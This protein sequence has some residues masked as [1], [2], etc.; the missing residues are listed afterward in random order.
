MTQHTEWKP[1]APLA[2]AMIGA[3]TSLS[4]QWPKAMALALDSSEAGRAYMS[5]FAYAMKGAD[6]RAI[7]MAARE[8]VA[9]ASMP[10]KP[11]DLGRLAREIT[12]T[13][14]P[15]TFRESSSSTF[16]PQG[17]SVEHL[18]NPAAIDTL[19]HRAFTRLGSWGLVTEVWSLLWSTAPTTEDQNTVR[20]GDVP[21]DVFDDAVDAVSRGRRSAGHR[22]MAS[23]MEF[24]S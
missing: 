18:R 14:F 15:T 12:A 7:P 23:A 4:R 17:Q 8:Y 11:S 10:P 20:L 9:E 5:D 21:R 22:P 19:G 16:T 13:H 6:L 3:L 1:S 2:A 24:A